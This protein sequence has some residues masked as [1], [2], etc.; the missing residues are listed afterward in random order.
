MAMRKN[1]ARTA[2]TVLLW[3]LI[4]VLLGCVA[5]GVILWRAQSPAHTPPGSWHRQIDLREHAVGEARLWLGGARLGEQVDAEAAFPAIPA[6]L[7][8]TLQKDG[9]WQCHVERE[10]YE[11]A[12]AAAAQGMAAALR[13]LLRLRIEDT[14]RGGGTEEYLEARIA[15]AV[16]MSSLEYLREHGPKLLPTLEELENS[17]G[18]EGTY[19]VEDGRL[20]LSGRE[21]ADFAVSGGFLVL[22]G[23]GGTEV[24]THG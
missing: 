19:R 18:G 9:T 1:R 4:I 17:F 22:S 13:E 3:F 11:A 12:E 8:L 24:Y 21:A 7:T 16:G 6:E 15:D 20:L 2:L 14:G 23:P 10:S 5:G